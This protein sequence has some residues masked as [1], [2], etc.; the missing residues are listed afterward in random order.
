MSEQ[1]NIALTDAECNPDD[2]THTGSVLIEEDGHVSVS[3]FGAQ[4]ATCRIVAAKAMAWA[5]LQ[6]QEQ[7]A[8]IK[9]APGGGKVCVD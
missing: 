3:G 4:N 2:L 8:A 5:I 9:A 1:T 7:L 6:L